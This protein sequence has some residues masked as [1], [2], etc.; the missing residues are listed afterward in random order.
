MNGHL[1]QISQ[2]IDDDMALSSFRVL[3]SVKPSFLAG[4]NGF[5]AL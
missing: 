3:A 2:R 5:D 1:N 4:E